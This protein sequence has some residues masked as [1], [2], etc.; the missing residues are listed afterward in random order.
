MSNVDRAPAWFANAT[1]GKFS[2]TFKCTDLDGNGEVTFSIG[3]G[4]A[5][6]ITT[7]KGTELAEAQSNQYG[8]FYIVALGPKRY[9]VSRRTSKKD[10]AFYL[11][12]KLARDRVDNA[13]RPERPAAY[14][15]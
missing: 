9:F 2:S 12:C 3:K 1:E 8:L 11:L 6:S 7:P 10:G 4:E 15:K 14:G 5:L 13:G